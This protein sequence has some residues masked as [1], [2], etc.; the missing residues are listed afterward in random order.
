MARRPIYFVAKKELF[1]NRPRRPGSSNSLGAFPIDRGAA[2]R[3]RWTPRAAILERGDGVL[4]FPEGT[5]TR[6]G[7]LGQPKRGV[8]RLALETG[9]PVVPVA[10]IG[11]EDVRRGW[12]IRPHKVRIRAGAPA[13]LPAGRAA[14]AATSPPRSPTASGRASSSSGSGSAACRRCAAPPSSAPARGA[15][16]RRR[17]R[18]RRP[19]GRARHARRRAGRAIAAGN[20][21]PAR[22]RA[23]RRRIP[24]ATST[25]PRHDLVCLAVPSRALPAARRRAG[26]A[27]PARAGVLVSKG[28]VAP[29]RRAARRL[30]RRAPRRA[31]S[32]A[33]AARRTPPTRSSTAPRSSS[34]APSQAFAASRRVLATPASTSS[35]RPTSPASSSPAPRKNAAVARRRRRRD[36]RRRR[37]RRRRRQGLR[38]GRRARAP[39][40]AADPETFAGLAG[41]GDLVATVV[42]E[43]SRNRAPASCSAAAAPADIGTGA[44]PG[45]RGARHGAAAR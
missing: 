3:T 4:I 33:S 10:V 5:R 34:P 32:P 26:A 16:P 45:R 27:I 22:R 24:P 8:G 18:P 43:G 7:P 13:D 38:R 19:R 42:A 20:A 30:R 36:R 31:P 39:P 29:L 21:L 44:R 17:A 14:L 9:A 25:S 12:R 1:I 41:A 6:P 23:R 37:R 2:T 40:A 35:A 28:L 15:R 11:T